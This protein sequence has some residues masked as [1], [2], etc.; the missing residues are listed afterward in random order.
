MPRRK[1]LELLS[2]ML[3]VRH[4]PDRVV[5]ILRTVD[6]GVSDFKIDESPHKHA[7]S[8]TYANLGRWLVSDGLEDA[9]DRQKPKRFRLG[10]PS[11]NGNPVYF[12]LADESS[13]TLQLLWL[14][15]HALAALEAGSPLV[16][17]EFGSQM[18]TKASEVVFNLFNDPGT[19][20]KG[21]QLIVATHDTNMMNTKGLRRDQVWFTEKDATGATHL[22]PLTDFRLRDGDNVERG[23]LQGRFGAIPFAG[24]LPLSFAET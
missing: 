15:G 3:A 18:H 9:D 5:E 24:N 13:G 8:Q 6:I 1:D 14:L 10:H 20:P 19:N 11:S 17:D 12:D 2:S 22:Y 7:L 23:Y 16:V 4:S 21:A